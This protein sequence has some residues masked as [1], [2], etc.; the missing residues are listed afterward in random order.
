MAF[1]GKQHKRCKL[2][3]ADKI[4]GCHMFYVSP[5]S[6]AGIFR[7]GRGLKFKKIPNDVSQVPG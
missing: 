7:G 5:A 1:K 3:I 2:S 6:V 4:I